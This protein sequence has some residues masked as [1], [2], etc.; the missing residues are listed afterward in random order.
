ME[1]QS[2]SKPY[3]FKVDENGQLAGGIAKFVAPIK[4]LTLPWTWKP[5]VACVGAAGGSPK[6][7]P[8]CW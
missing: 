3:W 8:V 6:R 1:V 5:F 4:A 2:G 7:P